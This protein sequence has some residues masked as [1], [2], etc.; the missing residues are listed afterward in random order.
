MGSV[1][2]RS[3]VS[4]L[5]GLC[6]DR[7]KHISRLWILLAFCLMPVSS[8]R[9]GR[10]PE[11][12]LTTTTGA[13]VRII[14]FIGDGMGTAQRAAAQW[15]AVGFNGHL[16]MDTLPVTGWSRTSNVAGGVTDSAA[17]A[18]AMATGVKT[19]NGKIG[20]GPDGTP[21]STILEQAQ[22]R[23][24]AVGLV[25]NTPLAHATPAAFAAHTGSRYAMA[26]IARQLLAARVDVL[27]G[28]GENAFLPQWWTG[29]YPEP[30]TR[31]DGRNL[32]A[33]AVEAGYTYVWD[34]A[35]LQAAALMHAPRVLGLFADEELP[36]PQT[37][38]LA[39]LT[40]HAISIL[41]RRPE[42]FFLMVEGGQIDWACHAND[43]AL[44]IGDTL[45][46]DAAVAAGLRYAAG[47][48]NTLVIVT[49]D[50]ETGGMALS[51]SNNG[52]QAFAM[53]DGTPFYVTWTTDD[54]TDTNVLVNAQ[55]P[56]SSLATGIYENTHIYT[57][58]AMAL[59]A[60]P[61][62][63]L[64]GS[65]LA[66]PGEPLTFAAH[67]NPITATLPISYLWTATGQ[68]PL[69]TPGGAHSTAG[70]T[71]PLTGTYTL[72]VTARTPE[73]TLTARRF[74]ML[75]HQWYTLYLPLIQKR[76]P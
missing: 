17:A 69:T 53:P 47:L 56:W 15:A 71:W 28:G 6:G 40:E 35:G 76:A 58:M 59:T 57:L 50:H 7:V 13:P 49:S 3:T 62:L 54:H 73:V 45:A 27:L 66:Y 25:T 20:L 10:A 2:W 12:P 33:E 18:T 75:R 64:D 38:T 14:L 32:V 26:E 36:R 41:S 34:A 61:E 37:P 21:L 46:F 23:G 43:A 4:N 68:T 31:T 70:F 63:I 72:T 42:G 52:G 24:L 9:A 11:I 29:H 5:V 44:A 60:S 22:A 74:I 19:E 16:V 55:G 30:G 67:F 48:E 51:L 8:A 1:L 65:S 39:A